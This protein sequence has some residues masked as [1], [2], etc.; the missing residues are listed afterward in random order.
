VG[1]RRLFRVFRVRGS[2]WRA[3]AR[4]DTRRRVVVCRGGARARRRGGHRR[5]GRGF[6]AAR[7]E[8]PPKFRADRFHGQRR[9]GVVGAVAGGARGLG[10]MGG[11]GRR[12]RATTYTPSELWQAKR[13]RLRDL[14]QLKGGRESARRA[15]IGWGG[16]LVSEK[17]G[18]RQSRRRRSRSGDGWGVRKRTERC[19]LGADS[20]A[21]PN[22]KRT[23][24][25]ASGGPAGGEVG[26]RH[27]G[28]ERVLRH[29]AGVGR[30]ALLNFY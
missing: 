16:K 25:R 30:V 27:A 14:R 13:S 18:K 22:D 7:V 17:I 6:R 12:L 21:P 19:R 20:D 24:P 11:R 2:V 15:R 5:G 8:V 26:Q 28:R 23:P 9:G 3:T 1:A 4:T 29:A 10:R